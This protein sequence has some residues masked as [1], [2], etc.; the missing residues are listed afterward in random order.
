MKTKPNK[1]KTH[2]KYKIGDYVIFSHSI[3]KGDIGKVVS[4]NYDYIE[5]IFYYYLIQDVYFDFDK[6]IEKV[7]INLDIH[8]KSGLCPN[9]YDY[10]ANLEAKLA[11]SENRVKGFVELFDKKQHENYEQFCEIQELKQQ[12]KYAL[13]DFN[14]IQEE[15]D[16]LAQQLAEKEKEI[17]KYRN[18]NMIVVGRRSQGKKHLMQ[19]KIKELQNQTVIAELEKLKK[20]INLRPVVVRNCGY[21]DFEEILLEDVYDVIDNQINEL[22]EMK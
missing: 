17:E 8:S 19:I 6:Y 16:K 5:L 1:Q 14:D 4:V 21:G 18:A 7:E 2:Y 12:L 3:K 22:K 10:V 13:K 11:E 9:C 15:N 20:E